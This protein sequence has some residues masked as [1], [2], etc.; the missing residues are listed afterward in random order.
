[1]NAFFCGTF[2]T[3]ERKKIVFFRVVSEINKY[4]NTVITLLALCELVSKLSNVLL[5]YKLF[6]PALDKGHKHVCGHFFHNCV[7][8][9]CRYTRFPNVTTFFLPF[10]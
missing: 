2:I 3:S 5:V 7:T 8:V 4:T 9:F 10:R 6:V 1:M